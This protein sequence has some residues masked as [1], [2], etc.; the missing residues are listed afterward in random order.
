MGWATIETAEAQQTVLFELNVDTPEA[1]ELEERFAG[2]TLE[3]QADILRGIELLWQMAGQP[4]A[5]GARDNLKNLLGH[6]DPIQHLFGVP[7]MIFLTKD[8]GQLSVWYFFPESIS[9]SS[10]DGQ[11]GLL[12]RIS[13]SPEVIAAF[14]KEW[15]LGRLPQVQQGAYDFWMTAALP[16]IPLED[17]DV[18]DGATTVEV[19][20]RDD[21]EDNLERQLDQLADSLVIPNP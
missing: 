9:Q 12:M 20:P 7:L 18:F 3:S 1:R 6:S 11:R 13:G 16:E 15:G 2:E 5:E 8:G 4:E 17:G 19:E 10:I 21:E 14:A